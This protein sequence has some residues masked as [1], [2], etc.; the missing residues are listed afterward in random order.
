MEPTLGTWYFSLGDIFQTIKK[1]TYSG[2]NN[3]N[4]PLGEEKNER[5]EGI[6]TRKDNKGYVLIVFKYLK[7]YHE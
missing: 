2:E 7:E 1:Q 5:I 4:V 6:Q 3:E